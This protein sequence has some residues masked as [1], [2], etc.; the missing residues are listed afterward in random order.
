MSTQH[1]QFSTPKGHKELEPTVKPQDPV[2]EKPGGSLT[3]IPPPNT[4]EIPGNSPILKRC[5][6]TGSEGY[7]PN[8]YPPNFAFPPDFRVSE[9]SRKIL[10]LRGGGGGGEREREREREM[11][12]CVG[13]RDKCRSGGFHQV[14]RAVMGR[15][16]GAFL[17]LLVSFLLLTGIHLTALL[18]SPFLFLFFFPPSQPLNSCFDFICFGLVLQQPKTHT[19]YR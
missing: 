16:A 19:L 12:V 2:P 6:R 8:T 13:E 4:R 17:L 5:V 11:C 14:P 1:Q 9:D 18:F 10:E 7:Q 15:C 3:P